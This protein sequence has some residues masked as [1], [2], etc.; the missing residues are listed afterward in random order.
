MKNLLDKLKS[1]GGSIVC[2]SSCSQLELALASES[3]RFFVDEEGYGF[4]YRPPTIDKDKIVNEVAELYFEK[5]EALYG[6]DG[7]KEHKLLYKT[8]I[9]RIIKQI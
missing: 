1:I 2:S 8:Q 7:L 3:G 4:V 9:E 6:A 5:L